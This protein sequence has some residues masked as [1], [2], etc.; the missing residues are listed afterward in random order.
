MAEP[1][2]A[3]VPAGAELEP[4]ERVNRHC[5]RLHA[6]DVAEHDAPGGLAEKRA[7]AVAQTGQVGA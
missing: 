6:V 5:V 1:Y 2:L 7:D 4:A 3:P